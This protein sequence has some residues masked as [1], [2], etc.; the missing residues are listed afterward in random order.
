MARLDKARN[1]D[2]GI[3]P[4]RHLVQPR[5]V[6]TILRAL[7]ALLTNR[8]ARAESRGRNSARRRPGRVHLVRAKSA[9]RRN[10]AAVAAGRTEPA[11][12]CNLP[13]AIAGAELRKSPWL[14][15]RDNYESRRN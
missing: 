14:S 12:C 7:A 8:F 15:Y 3:F 10:D 1:Y 2:V 13:G 5:P 4:L 9:D 6:R 11:L